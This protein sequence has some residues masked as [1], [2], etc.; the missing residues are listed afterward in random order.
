MAEVTNTAT[1]TSTSATAANP[2]SRRVRRD[3]AAAYL[4][5]SV[6]PT[7]RMVWISL[8]STASILRRR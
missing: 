1:V 8:G 4:V 5:R 3:I 2:A 6:Y 7:P